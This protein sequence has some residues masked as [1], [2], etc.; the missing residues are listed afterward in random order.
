MYKTE[1]S[2]LEFSQFLSEGGYSDN[3]YWSSA[4]WSWKTANNIICPLNW[5]ITDTPN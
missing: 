4:G 1:I 5:E 2:N 3:S